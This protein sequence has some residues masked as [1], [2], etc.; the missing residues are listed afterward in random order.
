MS[1]NAAEASTP[2]RAYRGVPR[3]ERRR[4]QH[5]RLLQAG[6]QVF[7]ERGYAAAKIEEIVALAR[8]SRNSFY[9]FFDNKEDCLRAIFIIGVGRLRT[10]LLEAFGRDLPPLERIRSGVRALART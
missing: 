4:D 10:D 2:D 3:A 5:D 8:V 1:A 7:A 6:C 9:E